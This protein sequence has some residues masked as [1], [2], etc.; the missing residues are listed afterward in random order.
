MLCEHIKGPD[1]PTGAEIVTPREDLVR[2]Y[3]TGHRQR[4]PARAL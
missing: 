3:E 1:Y 2:C 4:P